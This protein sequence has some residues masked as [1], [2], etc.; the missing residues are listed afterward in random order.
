MHKREYRWNLRT[1]AEEING[2]LSPGANP[3]TVVKRFNVMAWNCQNGD[4]FLPIHRASAEMGITALNKGASAM[5]TDGFQPSQDMPWIKVPD[6][7]TATRAI[8][9]RV[10]D[11]F[12]GKLI[13]I[14]GSAGK[15]TTKSMLN[16]VLKNC[17]ETHT[18]ISNQNL[19]GFT[20]ATLAGMPDNT[21]Y[22]IF[23]IA[24]ETPDTVKESAEISRPHIGVITS[25]GLNHGVHHERPEEGIVQSKTEMFFQMEPSGI[26]VLPTCDK[27]Y[28][29]MC[30][31]A[32]KSGRVSR[33]I[34]C[35]QNL[36]DDIR[37]VNVT[38]NA[39]HSIVTVEVESRLVEYVVPMMGQHMV[40]DSLLVAGCLL[41]LD[42]PIEN[43]DALRDYVTPKSRLE[44]FR[45]AYPDKVI[46]L[47]DDSV[48][49]APDQVRALLN[50][51]NARGKSK[52]RL[53]V[54]GDM[55]E[56]GDRAEELHVMLSSEIDAS[57]LDLLVTIGPLSKKLANSVNIPGASF[58]NSFEALK[59]INALVQD[60]DLV[61]MKGSAGMHMK[62][63]FKEIKR[64][65]KMSAAPL[66]WSI[67][68]E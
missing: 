68:Q 64:V 4:I 2:Q 37:L 58:A 63:I 33:I 62:R 48:N 8:A 6:L 11:E 35:G 52:R 40:D 50:A 34:A 27:Y 21:E 12:A 61:A 39:T 31:R 42:L 20:V 17:G 7:Q 53:L 24:M 44:R 47:I 19:V 36:E 43:M 26:A 13:G 32:K 22:A 67:D 55:L 57:N 1:L 14:T 66:D 5:I 25:I 18:S 16:Y 56:L 29:K 46:E 65:A 10:R 60:G 41:A 49:A 23:E 54:L 30:V 28:D 15:S 51:L 38:E 3:E 59:E 45:V 9:G